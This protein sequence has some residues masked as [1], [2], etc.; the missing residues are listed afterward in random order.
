MLYR[1]DG[2]DETVK[3][4]FSLKTTTL[5]AFLIISTFTATA[6]GPA[7]A[8]TST[9]W[10]LVINGL[11]QNPLNLT[12]D[13]LK[14]MPQTTEEATIFCV[15]FPSQIVTTGIWTGVTLATLLQQAG[16]QPSAVKVAFFATDQYAT[17][18]NLVSAL[19]PAV[20]VAY[21]KDGATLSETL[22]LVVPGRW[23]YKWISQLTTIT[24]M[25]YDFKGKWE[26]QGYSDDANMQSTPGFQN[27]QTYINPGQANAS[28]LP[29]SNPP[30]INSTT[31][32]PSQGSQNSKP[33][34]EPQTPNTTSYLPEI[35]AAA[36]AAVI[37]LLLVFVAMRRH[38]RNPKIS[39]T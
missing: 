6:T 32:A 11:V 16:V 34:R 20:I 22:R 28:V 18:L 29:S 25:D 27:T 3:L 8:A 17:D 23:G 35:S 38:N 14:A 13:D 26:S 36:F 21:A 7:K 2:S 10:G 5:I 4:S 15:D 12:V 24:L 37:V 30:A 33:E 1:Y 39:S 19:D 9:D 31:T